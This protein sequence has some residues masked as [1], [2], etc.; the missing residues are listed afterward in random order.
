MCAWNPDAGSPPAYAELHCVSNFSFLRGASHPEEL[1]DTAIELGYSALAI[2]DECSLAGVVRAHGRVREYGQQ[3]EGPLDFQLII[4]SEFA[5]E[6]G[7]RLIVL[8]RDGISYSRLCRLITSCR[9][10]APKGSYTITSDMIEQ[11]GLKACCLLLVPPCLPAN[12]AQLEPWFNWFKGLSAQS[13]IALELHYG[14]YDAKH[15]HWLAEVGARHA[16]PLVASGDVHMHT[17]LL[18]TS[19]AADE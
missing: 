10:A 2:T 18:Y 19:D 9:R 15:L 16:L 8:V 3:S 4:G 1:V 14:L 5:L 6:D 7:F 12:R 11:A 17:C 13:G